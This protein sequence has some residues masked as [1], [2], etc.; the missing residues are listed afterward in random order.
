MKTWA[1]KALYQR[2]PIEAPIRL[3]PRMARSRSTGSAGAPRRT[4]VRAATRLIAVY[5]RIAM[6]VVPAASPSIPSVRFTP[7]AAP[8]MM[9]KASTYQAYE[10]GTSTPISGT[11][12]EVE[13]PRSDTTRPTMTVIPAS[14]TSFQRPA[15][16]SE[17]RRAIFVQSSTKPIAA[18]PSVTK[19]AVSAGRVCFEKARNGIAIASMIRRPPIAGVPRFTTCPW[20]PS[21]LICWPNSLRRRNSMNLGPATIE[22][23]IEMSPARRT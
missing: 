6:V 4:A 8:A 11:Y 20:G 12:T 17:R 7:F 9:K 23:T 2:N 14:Q 18:H 21:S 3:A 15:R 16:P 10:S 1:G 19:K 13:K 22:M 5:V